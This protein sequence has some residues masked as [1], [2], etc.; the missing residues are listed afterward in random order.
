MSIFSYIKPLCIIVSIT[1]VTILPAC[2]N[3]D[4][5]EAASAAGKPSGPPISKVDGYIVKTSAL[6]DNL[7]LSGSII[8]NEATT[9][10]PEIS[11]RLIYLN[12]SEG[13]VVGKGT[14]L[15][16]IYDGDLV[17]QLNKLKVQ[18]QVAEQTS[19][20][21]EELLKINGISQQE[22]DLAKLS[23]SNLQADINIVRS[24]IM[25]TEIKAPFTGT[26]GLSNISPGAYVTPQTIITTIRQNSQL[27]LDF[28]L[29][30]KY[31]GKIKAGQLVN[32]TAEGNTKNYNAKI[33]A[34]ESGIAEENRSLQIR[35]LILNND[36]K[37][38]PG[39]FVKVKTNFEPDPEAIMI[40]SQ[41]VIP[42]ARGKQV[43][44]YRN[45]IASFE[46]IITG[47]RDSANVQ[48]TNGLKAGDTIIITG[49]MSLK[50]GGK[51]QLN[52]MKTEK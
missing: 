31:S 25:R 14:L 8:A 50:T 22:Y 4:K 2:N 20:R 24:N 46:N 12:K 49:L 37:L 39:Q 5:K 3:K 43:A 16:K 26:V 23:I 7:E 47:A 6:T 11:G 45:G 52:K 34:F 35:T 33:I 10:N 29:P 30:E 27:K 41:A 38:L 51:V 42:Q 13:K 40:P 9:I 32:F 44:I 15:A 19:K 36:G 48:V 17:A 1:G 21:Y 28:T 18:V